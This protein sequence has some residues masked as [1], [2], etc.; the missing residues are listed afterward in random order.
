MGCLNGTICSSVVAVV[1]ATTIHLA[2]AAE[3]ETPKAVNASDL[4]TK[5]EIIGVLARPLGTLT[6]IRGT[7]RRVNWKDA[8]AVFRVSHIDGN[9]TLLHAEF[10]NTDVH[11]IWS[12]GESA[13]AQDITWDWKVAHNGTQKPSETAKVKEGEEWEMIGAERGVFVVGLSEQFWNE[14]G[15]AWIA[16]SPRGYH[17]GYTFIAVRRIQSKK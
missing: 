11:P 14:I 15:G 6:T 5:T 10:T 13:T 12:R 16:G 4:L 2:R 9:S 8:V 7:W 17:P 1:V 3:N